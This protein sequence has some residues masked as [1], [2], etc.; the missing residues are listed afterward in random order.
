MKEH[1]DKRFSEEEYNYGKEPNNFLKEEL[2]Q[3]KPGNILFIGEGEGRNAVYAAS[4]GWNVDAIDFSE[5]GKLKAEK[6]AEEL[7]VKINYS[8][9]NFTDYLPTESYYDAVGIFF[10]HIENEL[11]T[12]LFN[13]IISSLKPAGKIIFEGFD[14]D[15]INYKS[16]G[17]KDVELL[18]SLEEVVNEFIDLEFDKLSKEKIY[19]NEGKGHIGDASVIRFI[20]TKI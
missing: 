14:K 6:L 17:P 19:L 1:W 7:N 20:G 5:A 8:V 4:L 3:L 9:K 12:S 11:R 13:R 10:I 18:Y 16:G 15:Q 2:Q